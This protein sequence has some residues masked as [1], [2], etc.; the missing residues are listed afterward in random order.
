MF[1]KLYKWYQ[2]VS[3]VGLKY[4]IGM[5]KS[6]NSVSSQMSMPSRKEVK[7]HLKATLIFLIYSVEII[8]KFKK[9]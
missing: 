8:W 6:L 4:L 3:Q 9:K 7:C 1:L 5:N 2:I